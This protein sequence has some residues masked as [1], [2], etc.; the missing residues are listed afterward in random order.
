MK[1]FCLLLSL[2]VVLAGCAGDSTGIAGGGGGGSMSEAQRDVA[3]NSAVNAYMAMSGSSI[4]Q[5]AAAIPGRWKAIS[6]FIDAGFDAKSETFWGIFTDGVPF[7]FLAGSPP[8]PGHRGGPTPR[9]ADELPIPKGLTLIDSL[10]NAFDHYEDTIKAAATGH[11]YTAKV[12]SGDI[13][14]LISINGGAGIHWHTHGG[15]G[16]L[17][18]AGTNA[19]VYGLWTS[20]V[21]T[22]T[23]TAQIEALIKNGELG[24][25]SAATDINLVPQDLNGNN[26][27]DEDEKYTHPRHYMILPKFVHN[28]MSTG[29]NSFVWIDACSAA[30]DTH[31]IS[32]FLGKGAD[33]F[34]GWD[35]IQSGAK[36]PTTIAF[37]RMFAENAV[38]PKDSPPYRPESLFD[39]IG[40]LQRKGLD[41]LTTEG[42]LA[43]LKYFTDSSENFA[44]LRPSIQQCSVTESQ[45]KGPLARLTLE[46]QF[47]AARNYDRT[48][49]VDDTPIHIVSWSPTVIQCDLPN[50]GAGSYGLVEVTANGHKSNQVPITLW[51]V[52]VTYDFRG[53]GS[54]FYK[55]V[56][57]MNFRQDVHLAR[58]KPWDPIK[59]AVKR[60][61]GMWDSTATFS[62]G[63]QASV[64]GGGTEKWSGGGPVPYDLKPQ[65]NAIY[66]LFSIDFDTNLKVAA[67]CAYSGNFTIASTTT[68]PDQGPAYTTVPGEPLTNGFDMELDSD[69]SI[70]GK[71]VTFSAG[72]GTGTLSWATT[73]G[74]W[75]P[76]TMTQARPKHK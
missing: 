68:Y 58:N 65:A 54:L 53:R 76:D 1:R 28:H 44:L 70:K 39:A 14:E 17:L 34:V 69:Y 16:N 57:N 60:L 32:E 46:G 35:N 9:G 48:V 11:G 5:K 27:I 19:E 38:T 42:H 41:K 10:G 66:F 47:G 43:T 36:V 8:D 61:A 45:T 62:S 55:W 21:F 22:S 33:V 50:T 30:T 6:G 52:Q 74:V 71:T 26:I 56:I 23:P 7:M 73:G 31:L 49:T 25:G 18:G 13:G 12:I 75:T 20:T 2:A 72:E 40:W 51:K 29:E 67:E 64:P 63:G 3:S 4:A 15:F 59:G 24:V 37:D